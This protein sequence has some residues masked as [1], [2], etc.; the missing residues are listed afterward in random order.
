M[1]LSELYRIFELNPIITTDS[2]D[3]PEGSIFFALKGDT[4]NGN[5]FAKQTLEKGCAYAVVDDAQFANSSDKRIIFVND[6][7]KTLQQLANYHRHQ[8][9][10]PI[11]QITGTNGKTTTKELA[12]I[13]LSQAHRVLFTQG[14]FN[15]HIGVPK[16]LLRLTREHDIAVIETGANHP[17]EIAEL[18]KIVDADCGLITN[19]G[20]AHLEGFGSFEGVIRT[21]GELYDYLR[22]KP[23]CFIF[24]HHDNEYLKPIATNLKAIRYG[25]PQKEEELEVSGEVIE[26]APYLKFRWRQKNGHW[27]EVQTQL[28][29]SYN[30]DN[31]LAAVTIGLHFG[32]TPDR[33]DAALTAYLPNNNRSQLVDTGKNHIVIDAYNANPTSMMA[34]LENFRDMKVDKKMLILGEM[35]ELGSCSGEEHQK[36]V[37]FLVAHTIDQVWLVGKNFAATTTSFRCFKDVDEVKQE[38]LQHPLKGYYILL[39]GS[40]GTKLFQL[41]DSL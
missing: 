24:L 11:L 4:F 13:V 27:H 33:I 18:S 15:N 3:C 29:G 1:Q 19:V 34:A 2:R 9:G 6:V 32:V 21:K 23:D 28:I 37:D 40:N 17:G 35:R 30:I 8:L 36:I 12:S 26:C 10:T 7:L 38:L 14:N 31:L 25:S 39:K 41:S 5:E 16:T 22:Q 20:K